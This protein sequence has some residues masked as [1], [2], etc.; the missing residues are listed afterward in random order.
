MEPGLEDHEWIHPLN[1]ELCCYPF[2]HQLGQFWKCHTWFGGA[3][4]S[5]FIPHQAYLTCYQGFVVEKHLALS[6]GGL[7]WVYLKIGSSI[8]S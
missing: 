8:R 3:C 6:Y 5:S 7:P 2:L 4:F 1:H